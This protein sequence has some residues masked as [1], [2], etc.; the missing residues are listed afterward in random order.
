MH[1]FKGLVAVICV[2]KCF[3]PVGLFQELAEGRDGGLCRQGC[4]SVNGDL[5]ESGARSECAGN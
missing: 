4:W 2:C 3:K 5:A 1:V